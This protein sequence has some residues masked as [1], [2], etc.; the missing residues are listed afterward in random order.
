MLTVLVLIK[1]LHIRPK[2][3]GVQLS[4][5][6]RKGQHLM[7]R[8]FD[9]SRLVGVHMARLRRQDALVGSQHGGNDHRVGLGTSRQKI[10]IRLRAAAGLPDFARRALTVT[11]RL[12]SRQRLQIRLRESL[13][14]LRVR[15][16]RI[17]VLK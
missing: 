2:L 10:H 6:L 7:A 17:I 4:L 15:P 3:S 12:I 8:V 9:G 16:R 13:K 11:V 1:P 14:K 5:T